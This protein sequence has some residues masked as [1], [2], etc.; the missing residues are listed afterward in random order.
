MK[1]YKQPFSFHYFAVMLP[2]DTLACI[3]FAATSKTVWAGLGF[4]A[5]AIG[6]F[7]VWYWMLFAE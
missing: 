7:S 6:C 2:L 4:I 1:A 5:L 3:V